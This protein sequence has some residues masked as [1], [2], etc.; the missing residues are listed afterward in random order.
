M[1]ATISL[2][3]LDEQNSIIDSIA[4][5]ESKTSGE[6]R[7]H[8]ENFCLGDPVKRAA[9][10]FS[11]IGMNKTKL[12]NGVL[13]FLAVKSKKFSIVGDSGI[14]NIVS[15]DFW[16][17]IKEKLAKDFSE[18]KF[19]EGLCRGIQK[20]G[21]QLQTHFPIKEGDKNELANNI[22]FGKK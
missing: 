8:I 3:T 7:V 1:A 16:N 19:A 9:R 21:E 5:A 17:G 2:F 15:A 6:I 12:K 10:I 13:F 11:N 4:Q 22:S 18:N 14:N 20:A